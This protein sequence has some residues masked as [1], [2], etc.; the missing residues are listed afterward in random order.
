MI[1]LL[2]L[3]KGGGS[4]LHSLKGCV[5]SLCMQMARILV[6][7]YE[8]LSN[9]V[10]G[11]IWFYDLVNFQLSSFV[12]FCLIALCVSHTCSHWD[13]Y[14]QMSQC[15]FFKDIILWWVFP[16]RYFKFTY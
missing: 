13:G 5:L 7:A 2:L 11:F 3:Q 16:C 4:D 12:L 10:K 15:L 9:I 1:L 6:I 14:T 8:G